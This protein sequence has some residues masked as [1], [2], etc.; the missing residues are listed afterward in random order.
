MIIVLTIIAPV[1]TVIMI[2]N[3]RLKKIIKSY[4]EY[5]ILII[6]VKNAVEKIRFENVCLQN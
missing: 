2:K 3:I 5:R 4:K 6:F 1:K